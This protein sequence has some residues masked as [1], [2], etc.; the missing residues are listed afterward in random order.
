MNDFVQGIFKNTFA[1]FFAELEKIKPQ[2]TAE[3]LSALEAVSSIAFVTLA[4]S[5]SIDDVT[6]AEH[7][8]Q[9]AAWESGT[10]YQVGAIRRYDERLYRCV[11]A[12]TSQDDWTPDV[13]TSLW[14]RVGDPAEEYPA[15]S[16]PV[17]A[18]DAYGLGD[19]VTH[20]GKHWVSI[21]AANVWE[22]GVYGWEEAESNG[23]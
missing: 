20:N 7:T 11:Q 1:G 19:K 10:P 17:G 16:Q 4:E 2:S 23:D 12:H 9:F 18:H 6:A 3:R 13:A 14:S 8:E 22:P 5:G 15:W 21:A